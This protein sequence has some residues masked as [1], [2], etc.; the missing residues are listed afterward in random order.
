MLGG[1]ARNLATVWEYEA[2]KRDACVAAQQMERRRQRGFWE[3]WEMNG[4]AGG[5][6][7]KGLLLPH[8]DRLAGSSSEMTGALGCR[9]PAPLD[10]LRHSPAP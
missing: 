8:R 6:D 4:E 2:L 1:M 3:V 7:E 9:L 5:P 10:G